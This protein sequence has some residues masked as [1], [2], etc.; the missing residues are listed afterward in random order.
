VN[1]SEIPFGQLR[2]AKDLTRTSR[3]KVFEEHLAASI[4][5]I[6]LSEPI[7]VARTKDGRYVVVDGVMRVQAISSIRR[8]EPQRFKQVPAYVVPF[9]E[10]YEIRFQTDIYQDLLPSQ[11]AALVE[12]LHEASQINK[13]EIARFI[14]VSGATLRN[15]TGLWRL[16]QRGGL[17]KQIVDL[18]DHGVLPASNPYA[19]LRL[20]AVGLRHALETSF[21]GGMKAE[22]WMG[23]QLLLA[24]DE[25]SAQFPIK[26]VEAATEA[27]PPDCYRQDSDVRALKRGLGLRRAIKHPREAKGSDEEAVLNLNRVARRT[28]NPVVRTAARS[29][30]D[31]LK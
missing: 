28:R 23:Q 19:W 11:L 8:D 20:T 21:T 29:M 1:Y 30:R 10:R 16:I 17:F 22:K 15:Y 6:G 24:R 2:I 12:H 14:G 5:E 3:S 31:F 26:F 4:R 27:L 9:D 25:R 7:K 18:M 13:K